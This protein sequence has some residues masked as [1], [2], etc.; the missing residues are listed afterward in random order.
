MFTTPSV[1]APVAREAIAE[2]LNGALV[3]LLDLHSHAKVAHWNLWGPHFAPLHQLF[4][5]VATGIASHADDLA[6]RAVTLG[7]RAVGTARQVAARTRLPEYEV[8]AVR[9]LDHARLLAS[10]LE[11][12]LVG[13]RRTRTVAEEHGDDETVDLLIGIGGALEEHGWMLRATLYEAD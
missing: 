7:G 4:E 10:R 3:D 9:D 11:S 1:L 6:E 2:A 13:L 12:A 5:Q 8:A